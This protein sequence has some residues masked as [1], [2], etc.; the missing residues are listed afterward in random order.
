MHIGAAIAVIVNGSVLGVATAANRKIR[1]IPTRCD[2]T[3]HRA[4]STPTMFAMTTISGSSNDTP[5]MISM[6]VRN[7]R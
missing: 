1:K 5:K 2:L 4:G 6:S 3:S 7:D